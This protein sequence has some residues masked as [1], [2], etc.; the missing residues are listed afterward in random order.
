MLYLNGVRFKVFFIGVG[1][2]LVT[3]AELIKQSKTTINGNS[4]TIPRQNLNNTQ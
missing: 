1:D 4:K 3:V 2:F